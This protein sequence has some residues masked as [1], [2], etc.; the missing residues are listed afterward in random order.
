MLRQTHREEE[1]YIKVE[2]VAV[3]ARKLINRRGA[4][5]AQLLVRWSNLPDDATTWEDLSFMKR[6]FPEF[7]ID[8]RSLGQGSFRGVG[9]ECQMLIGLEK[10]KR[11][12]S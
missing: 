10:D 2:P 8:Q 6:K 5:V 11:G 7:D 9:N 3:L 4:P 12:M 1:G